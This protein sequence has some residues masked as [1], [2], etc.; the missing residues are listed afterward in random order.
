MRIVNTKITNVRVVGQDESIQFAVEY[1]VIAGGGA[2]GYNGGGG[3]G[4][5]G[6]RTGNATISITNRSAGAL[7]EAPVIR[8]AV[9]KGSIT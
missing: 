8:F 6:Y 9:I 1:L 3:G 2:G 5:G 4:A 7:A